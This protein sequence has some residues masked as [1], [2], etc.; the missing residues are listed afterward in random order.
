MTD[1]AAENPL[2]ARAS[3]M[4]RRKGALTPLILFMGF[5]GATLRYLLE[6]ALPTQ[7]GFPFATLSIN[8]FGCFVLE[9]INRYVGR[10]MHLPKPLVKSLGVGLVGA[11]TT[12]SA[13][14]TECLAFIL[15][16]KPALAALY[17]GITIAT[18]F[19]ASLAGHGACRALEARRLDRVRKRRALIHKQHA[20]LCAAQEAR[21]HAPET[22]PAPSERAHTD[23]KEENL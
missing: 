22:Q 21:G 6:V 8:L 2:S 9:L 5:L 13:F 18:T 17:I 20:D 11:F 15:A 16:G 7:G 1:T 3:A 19:L 23:G 4:L 14:S 10:R 12:L